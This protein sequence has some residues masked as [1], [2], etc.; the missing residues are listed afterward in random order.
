MNKAA[1]IALVGNTSYNYLKFMYIVKILLVSLALLF[2]SSLV[3]AKDSLVVAVSLL[4]PWKMEQDGKLEGAE[5]DV[6]EALAAKL[7]M[8]A[9]YRIL[10]F[11]RCLGAME[12]GKVDIMTGLLHSDEREQYIH[13]IKP[14]YKEKSNKVFYVLKEDADSIS[15]F[16]D[17][18]SLRVGIKRGV[19]YFPHFDQDDRIKKI[20]LNTYDQ[21]LKLLLEKRIDTFIITDSQGDFIVKEQGAAHE[22]VKSS[23]RY[24]KENKVYIG[25]SRQSEFL[26]KNSHAEKIVQDMIISGEVAKII[27]DFFVNHKLPI[28]DYR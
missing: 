10:P 22:V 6:V 24:D 13:Y 20:A 25:F 23:Y 16:E 21:A 8:E 9:V 15:T 4:E 7:E 28:P 14:P 3:Y 1:I 18:Y 27:D 12:D 19:K 11:K 17:L 5:I 2:C 26:K